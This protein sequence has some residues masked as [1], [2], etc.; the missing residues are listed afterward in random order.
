MYIDYTPEQTALRDQLRAY[1]DHLITDELV[2]E[3]DTIESGGPLYHKA[4]Q[5]LGADGWLGIG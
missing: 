4:M 5:Q 1:F 3:L 2:A